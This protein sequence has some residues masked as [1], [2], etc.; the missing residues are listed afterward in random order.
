MA[1]S[2]DGSAVFVTG[3]SLGIGT[4]ADVATVGYQ[5]DTGAELWSAR[6]NGPVD[7]FDGGNVLRVSPDSTR[8]VVAAHSF[9][10][11]T[12]RDYAVLGYDAGASPELPV[13][14]PWDLRVQPELALDGDQL[15]VSA[16][17]TNLG[18]AAGEYDAALLLDGEVAD[19]T[20]VTLAPGES[21]QLDWTLPRVAPGDHQIGVGHLR[22]PPR[23]VGCDQSIRGRH[24]GAV[25]VTDGVTCLAAGA[26]VVGPVDVQAGAGLV[27]TGATVSG[28][29]TAA[30][31]A[32]VLLRDTE[33][34]GP[35]TVTGT[36]GGLA[37]SGNRLTGPVSLHDNTTGGFAIVVAGNRIVGLLSCTGNAPAPV[38]QGTPNQVIG[39]KT[40]QCTDL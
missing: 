19:T 13:F 20:P 10:T 22:V 4:N 6:Y 18:T 24:V 28:Q 5:A 23:V 37:L 3:H 31:A 15:A 29:L 27:A 38:N 35:V 12:S 21:H 33:V 17:L 34:V 9:G 11:G 14:V 1:V 36:T 26:R 2:P 40:G 32:V 39:R 16:Q 25:T 30:G 8:V 7:S